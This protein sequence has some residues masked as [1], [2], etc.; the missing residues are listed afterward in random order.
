MQA[1][2]RTTNCNCKQHVHVVYPGKGVLQLGGGGGE[3]AMRA[4]V[5]CTRLP[6]QAVSSILPSALDSMSGQWVMR[7]RTRHAQL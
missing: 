4:A 6:Q 5:Y 2:I 1:G 3:S 7:G